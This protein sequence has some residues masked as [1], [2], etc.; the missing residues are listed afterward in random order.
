[1]L[2]GNQNKAKKGDVEELIGKEEDLK[3]NEVVG[4]PPYDSQDIREVLHGLENGEGDRTKAYIP[5]F[6][7][8]FQTG[9]LK[10]PTENEVRIWR[11]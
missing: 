8:T 2:K 3:Y 9:F 1:M 11:R 4:D 7:L 5:F 6:V 10:R